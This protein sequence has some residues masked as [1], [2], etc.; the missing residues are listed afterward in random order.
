M[1]TEKAR[2]LDRKRTALRRFDKARKAHERALQDM[3]H[4]IAGIEKTAAELALAGAAVDRTTN[5]FDEVPS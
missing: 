1:S 3:Q 2:L 4:A 5:A